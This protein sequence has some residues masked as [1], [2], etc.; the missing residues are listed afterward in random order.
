MTCI[1]ETSS[2]VYAFRK[3]WIQGTDQQHQEL[4]LLYLLASFPFRALDS[5]S[6]GCYSPRLPPLLLS[7]PGAKKTF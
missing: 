4:A 2:D 6:N 5:Q 3:S 1:I 7:N